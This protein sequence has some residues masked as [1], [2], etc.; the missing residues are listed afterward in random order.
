MLSSFAMKSTTTRASSSPRSS[1]RKCPPPAIVVCGWPCAPGIRAW[2]MRVGAARDRVAVAEGGEERLRPAPQHLPGRAVRRARRDRR[3][4]SARASGTGARP[5]CSARR[6]TARR[7]PRPP[8]AAASS[9][10]AALARCRPTGTPAIS[11]RTAASARNAVAGVS[12][13]VGRKVLAATTR[14]KRSGCSADEPQPDQAAPVLADQRDVAQVERVEHRAH[15]V[16]VALVGVVLARGGLV[17][18]AEADQVGGDAAVARRPSSTGIILRYRYDH[19]GS[20]C[21]S[22]TVGPLRGP[23]ST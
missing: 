5:P 2:K 1:C 11:A 10:A 18:A 23:S 16:D 8:R 15:P 13:P 4:W 14:A 19:D 12:S 21:S 22:R 9:G 7:R 17:G 3:A 6:E 20:P